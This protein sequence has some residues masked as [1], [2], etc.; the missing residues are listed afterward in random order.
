MPYGDGV[1]AH[2]TAE[3]PQTR[4]LSWWGGIVSA[5]VEEYA[6]AIGCD[7]GAIVQAVEE[8]A[9]DPLTDTAVSKGQKKRDRPTSH[10]LRSL[11]FTEEEF[12]ALLDAVQAGATSPSAEQ[13]PPDRSPEREIPA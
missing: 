4:E 6:A 9:A 11:A 3:D 8:G 10:E 1:R 2:F 12:E 13:I 7:P 5:T